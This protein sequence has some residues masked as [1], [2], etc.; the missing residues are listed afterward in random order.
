[1]TW[2]TTV[3]LIWPLKGGMDMFSQKMMGK[4]QGHVQ[5]PCGQ[6]DKYI[7]SSVSWN[8]FSISWIMIL[9]LLGLKLRHASKT[10]KLQYE[11]NNYFKWRTNYWQRH[12]LC[13]HTNGIISCPSLPFYSFSKIWLKANF[14]HTLS[15]SLFPQFPH[16][17]LNSGHSQA[18]L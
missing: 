16:P 10:A 11:K 13:F 5:L 3:Q 12:T 1:M 17:S 8:I 15:S 7:T 18:L 4:T 6:N 14:I 2:N 9:D